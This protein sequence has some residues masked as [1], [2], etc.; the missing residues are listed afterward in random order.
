M[1]RSCECFLGFSRPSGARTTLLVP[2]C[3]AKQHHEYIQYLTSNSTAHKRELTVAK[4]LCRIPYSIITCAHI[5][6]RQN[7]QY[8]SPVEVVQ[9]GL[10]RVCQSRLGLQP[11]VFTKEYEVLHGWVDGSFSG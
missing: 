11:F 10:A 7:V 8:A 1:A 5:L 9:L 3:E 2:Q 4:T 6:Y